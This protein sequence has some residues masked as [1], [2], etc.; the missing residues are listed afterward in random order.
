MQIRGGWSVLGAAQ[1]ALLDPFEKAGVFHGIQLGEWDYY[2]HR[3]ST[4]NAEFW[5]RSICKEQFEQSQ[6]LTSAS[7]DMLGCDPALLAGDITFEESLVAKLESS[8]KRGHRVL[9]SAAY[10]QAL[11][12]ETVARLAQHLGF[13]CLEHPIHPATGR[14]ALISHERL[15]ELLRQTLPVA[16][17]C[18]PIQWALNRNAAGWVLELSNPAGVRKKPGAPAVI[19]PLAVARIKVQT[20]FPCESATEWRSGKTHPMAE[21]ILVGPGPTVYC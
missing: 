16:V 20:R 7:E 10:R 18:D 12:A 17:S 13:E 11:G 9:Y 1:A 3:M 14:P 4:A 5:W 15:L 19:D 8:L 21:E 6:H 2:F